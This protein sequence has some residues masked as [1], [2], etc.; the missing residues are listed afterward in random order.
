MDNKET[1]QYDTA[2]LKTREQMKTV[3]P[4]SKDQPP[5]GAAERILKW[6]GWMSMCKQLS[7][8]GGQGHPPPPRKCLKMEMH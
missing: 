5:A 1:V 4:K 2:S 6:V 3:S 8:K 7:A